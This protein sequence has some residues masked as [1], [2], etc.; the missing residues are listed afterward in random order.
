MVNILGKP[1][2]SWDVIGKPKGTQLKVGV[3]AEPRRGRAFGHMIRFL[4]GELGVAPSA[5]DVAFGRL[6]VHKQRQIKAPA[7][8]PSVFQLQTT[9]LD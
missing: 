5:I 9:L 1:C 8:M 7:H 2:A 4:A 3:T 6:N